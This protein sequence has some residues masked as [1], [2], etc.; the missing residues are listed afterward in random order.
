MD[1]ITDLLLIDFSSFLT[2]LFAALFGILALISLLEKTA[3]HL[4]IELKWLRKKREDH[5]LLIATVRRL[6]AL[7][8]KHDGSVAASI[9]NDA[10]IREDLSAVSQKMDSISSQLAEMQ[11]KAD[12]TEMAKLKDTLVASYRKYKNAGEWSRLEHDAFWDLFHSYE[13]HGG[14]GYVHG[15]IEPAMQEL[16]ITD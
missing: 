16:I 15:V 4:G 13:A 11:K 10:L 12:E 6:D 1:A 2:T 14:N 9:R 3:D 5:A 7:Q 8:D